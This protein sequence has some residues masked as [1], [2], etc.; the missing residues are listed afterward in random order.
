MRENAD[1]L[2]AW[3]QGKDVEFRPD[4]NGDQWKDWD[5][6]DP[7]PVQS[8]FY[9]WRIKPEKKPDVV[10]YGGIHWKDSNVV[11][12]IKFGPYNQNPDNNLKLTFDG[13]TGELIKA[14]VIK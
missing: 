2:I 1:I 13:E 9:K 5:Y 12:T 7:P 14:E 11:N 10:E 6:R 3:A 8:K 4:D